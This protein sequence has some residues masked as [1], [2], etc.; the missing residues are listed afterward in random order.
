[1]PGRAGVASQ[2][3]I[4][5]KLMLGLGLVVG[6]MALL[7]GGT[8]RGLWSYYV[9][10]NSIRNR[11]A[12]LKAAQE[13][14]EA[15]DNLGRPDRR[16]EKPNEGRPDGEVPSPLFAGPADDLTA[17]RE[18]LERQIQGVKGK[19]AE[20]HHQLEDTLNR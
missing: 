15:V 1:M 3:R 14:R 18:L 8:L 7:L 9:T 16:P 4:R 20:Y 11:L 12:E 13:L 5:H 17:F 2:W 19:F 10:V 6:I